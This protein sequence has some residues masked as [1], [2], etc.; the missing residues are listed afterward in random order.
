MAG[1]QA[2]GSAA[3]QKFAPQIAAIDIS[4]FNGRVDEHAPWIV[5]ETVF[6]TAAGTPRVVQWGRPIGQE[7]YYEVQANAKIKALKEVYARFNR[8]DAN[9]D[10]VDIRSDV[11]RLPKVAVQPAPPAT[12]RG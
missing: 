2:D 12:P 10:Y 5:L 4:N 8:I 3:K 11:L 9:R 1:M 6:P 7:K